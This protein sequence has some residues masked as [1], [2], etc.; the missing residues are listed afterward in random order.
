MI[1][2]VEEINKNP[3]ILPNHTLGYEI[4]NACGFSN[5][6]QSALSLANGQDAVFDELNCTKANTVQAIIGHSGSTPTIGFAR[7][8]GRFHIPVVRCHPIILSACASSLPL[9]CWYKLSLIY[10]Y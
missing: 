9:L 7:I 10:I 4:F 3:N 8:A 6:L 5:I 2:A 1:F